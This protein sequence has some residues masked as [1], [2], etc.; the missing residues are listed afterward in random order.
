MSTI[1][2]IVAIIVLITLIGCKKS[3][4]LGGDMTILKIKISAEGEITV[5]GEPLPLDQVSAKL[6][7]LKKA[8]GTVMYYRENPKDEP[9][10]NAMKVMELVVENRLPIRLSAKPDFSDVVDEKGVSRPG[11]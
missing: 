1:R 4:P 6:A 9:H 5:D 10:P 7:E 8:N 11:K 3:Q 2:L